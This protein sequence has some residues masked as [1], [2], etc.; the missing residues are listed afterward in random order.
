ML[1]LIKLSARTVKTITFV[2]VFL[3]HYRGHLQIQSEAGNIYKCKT[4]RGLAKE[5]KEG[6]KSI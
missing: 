3:Y 4:C 6:K 1:F 5:L 2:S